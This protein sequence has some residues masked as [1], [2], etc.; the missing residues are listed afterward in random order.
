MKHK[1]HKVVTERV[2]KFTFKIYP[3]VFNPREFISSEI[4][5][6]FVNQLDLKNKNILDMGCGSGIVSIFAA[7]KG[8][9]CTAVDINPM[10]IKSTLENAAL[11]GFMDKI[12]AIESDLFESIIPALT[13][14]S[15]I[16]GVRGEELFDIIFFNPPYYKGKPKNNFERAF[17]AGENLEVVNHF[18]QQVKNFL[19]ANGAIYMIISSDTDIDLIKN[20]FETNQLRFEITAKIKKLF[21]TFYIV[22]SVL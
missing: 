2:G 17:K 9:S 13:P 15:S 19:P 21:E 1:L 6:G 22:K 10:A 16:R 18:A 4:F 12:T 7:F 20:I 14:F 5:A 3:T 11:N 8:A